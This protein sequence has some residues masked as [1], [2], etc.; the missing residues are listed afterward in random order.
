VRGLPKFFASAWIVAL[1]ALALAL[2]AYAESKKVTLSAKRPLAWTTSTVVAIGDQ[3]NHEIAQRVYSYEITSPDPDFNGFKTTNHVQAD[4]VAGTGSH[5]GYAVWPLKNG[6]TV[7]VKFEGTHKTMVKDGGAWETPF[8][9][10]FEF[11]GGTGKYKNIKGSST[12]K[13]K[14][15]PDGA[16][17]EAVV[18]VQY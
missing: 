10:K 9:G 8:E 14:A 16:G 3:P 1:T 2:P 13:G 7:Y 5:R 17:W 15:T 4:E 11:V 18:D 6:D 12:Y